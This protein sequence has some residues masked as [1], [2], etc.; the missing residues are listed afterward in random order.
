MNC[1]ELELRLYDEDCRHALLGETPVPGDVAAH[2][3][4]CPACRKTWSGAAVDT[5]RLT[6]DLLLEAP[7]SVTVPA[8]PG[9]STGPSL[10]D[11]VGWGELGWAITA[12]ALLAGLGALF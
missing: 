12:G 8:F 4:S 3:E 5:V 9:E 1:H 2:I 6:R 10:G 7:P 11:I